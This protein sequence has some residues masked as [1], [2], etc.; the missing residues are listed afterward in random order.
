MHWALEHSVGHYLDLSRAVLGL[1]FPVG[2]LVYA[3]VRRPA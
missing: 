3:I 1:M 2:Y